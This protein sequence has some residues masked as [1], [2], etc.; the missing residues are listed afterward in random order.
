[1]KKRNKCIPCHLHPDPEHWVRKGQSWKAKVAYE[2]EDDAW[3]FLNQNPKLRAQGMAVYR[4]R[5]C[6]EFVDYMEALQ[7]QTLYKIIEDTCNKYNNMREGQI[8]DITE[9]VD[10]CVAECA[11]EARKLIDE[12][13]PAKFF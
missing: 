6:K 9:A 8:N 13:Q 3:E 5:I 11:K 10:R 4:C 12:C 1:M 2:S 7:N